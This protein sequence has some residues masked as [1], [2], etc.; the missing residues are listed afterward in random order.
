MKATKTKY[1][2]EFTEEEKK[3]IEIIGNIADSLY[4][5]DLCTTLECENCPFYNGFCVTGT[6]NPVN[7]FR[8][9]IEKFLNGTD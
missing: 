4:E 5:D 1:A 8:K 7:D 9:R 6:D 2:I 3:A